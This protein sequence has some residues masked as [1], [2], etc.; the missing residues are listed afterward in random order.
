MGRW[1]HLLATIVLGLSG[2]LAHADGGAFKRMIEDP[3][4]A[5]MPD[6]AAL[7]AFDAGIQTLAIQ[8]R[9]EGDPSEFA[10][11]V[12][13]PSRPEVTACEPGVFKVL[14]RLFPRRVVTDRGIPPLWLPCIVLAGTLLLASR[15]KTPLM[16]ATV[17]LCFGGFMVVL[18]LPAMGTAR[19]IATSIGESTLEVRTQLVGD[20]EVSILE[21]KRA[22]EVIDWLKGHRFDVSDA[23][24]KAI[25]S[26]VRDGWCF[27]ASRGVRTRGSAAGETITPHPLVFRFRTPSPVYPM[28]LT[29]ANNTGPLAVTLYVFGS[30]TATADG[31]HVRRSAPI[32]TRRPEPDSSVPDRRP[33]WDVS[34]SFGPLL[35]LLPPGVM[36]ATCL[37]RR[38]HPEQMARDVALSIGEPE[39]LQEA[40]YT[41][42]AAAAIGANV[43]GTSLLGGVLIGLVTARFGASRSPMR[44][45]LAWAAISVALG[46]LVAGTRPRALS[47]TSPDRDARDFL[48]ALRDPIFRRPVASADEVRAIIASLHREGGLPSDV[49]MAPESDAPGGWQLTTTDQTVLLRLVDDF[50]QEHQLD[51]PLMR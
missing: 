27:V 42:D 23:A 11:V 38:L 10:W 15:M 20:H 12:P 39:T 18:L 49:A 3:K 47:P 37:T 25:A 5:T 34:I 28:R 46:V 32:S 14:P 51:W 24:G 44:F 9:F 21:A 19:A 29:G 31:W 22:E 4:A 8:T 1:I 17:F 7:I 30:G 26:Y 41:P 16:R 36:H 48:F 50:G 35:D 33:P 43:A 2:T 40:V 45:S 6:Q 13:L